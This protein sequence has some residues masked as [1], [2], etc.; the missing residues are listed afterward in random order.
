MNTLKG[1]GDDSLNAQQQGAL[2]CPVTGRT[3][4]VFFTAQ[5]DERSLFLLIVQRSVVNEGL[6]S[7][8]LGEVSGVS[9]GNPIKELVLQANVGKRTA[10]HDFVVTTARSQ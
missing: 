5:D 6:R 9:T 3:G 2:S 8:F 1:F 10:N 4:A 7:A